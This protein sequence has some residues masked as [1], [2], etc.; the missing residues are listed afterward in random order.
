MSSRMASCTSP[1]TLPVLLPVL[2]LLLPRTRKQEYCASA[3][4]RASHYVYDFRNVSSGSCNLYHCCKPTHLRRHG[5]V[6]GHLHLHPVRVAPRVEQPRAVLRVPVTKL[7]A[8]AHQ[9]QLLACGAAATG[10]HYKL[11]RCG[12]LPA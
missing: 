1:E 7:R 3:F 8:A 12:T 6:H 9:H 5:H 2:L 4:W 11:C 10:M